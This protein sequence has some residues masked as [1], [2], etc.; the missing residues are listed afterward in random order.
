MDDDDQVIFYPNQGVD[1]HNRCCGGSMWCIQVPTCPK[2]CCSSQP[3]A[4]PVGN[5][6][7][8]IGHMRRYM[9]DIHVA[10][11]TVRRVRR[12]VRHPAAV[13]VSDLSVRQHGDISIVR[14]PGDGLSPPDNVHR[15]GTLIRS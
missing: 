2:N 7:I 1:P 14:V 9:R 12:H 11:D 10:V 3:S 4:V 13:S 8:S 15:S 5:L 6:D